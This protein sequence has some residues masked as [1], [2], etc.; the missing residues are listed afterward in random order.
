MPSANASP[1]YSFK[2]HGVF[3]QASGVHPVDEVRRM[4]R[5]NIHEANRIA[6]REL[7]KAL[8]RSLSKG[9]EGQTYHPDYA[10]RKNNDPRSEEG[11]YTPSGPVDFNYSGRLWQQL[12]GRGRAKPS[13]DELQVWV[14]LKSRSKPRPRSAPGTF[15]S[16]GKLV[17]H[18]KRSKPSTK[19]N[20]FQID[21]QERDRVAKN[22]IREL[23]SG[24]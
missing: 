8:K 21:K 13:E 2:A 19:G 3:L 24:N 9:V 18:L 16:Y 4:F 6:K 15:S 7:A 14:G 1:S 5:E 12:V 17:D 23:L 20:P 10:E 22:T 11:P